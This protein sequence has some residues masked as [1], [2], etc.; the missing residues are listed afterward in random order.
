MLESYEDY[1]K[2][3]GLEDKK[4]SWINWKID[5]YQYTKEKARKRA[6]SQYYP[7]S[8]ID[9]EQTT[10]G[11]NI[12]YLRKM[13]GFTLVEMSKELNISDNC[14]ISRWERG[15]YIPDA[16][17]TQMLSDYFNVKAADLMKRNLEQEHYQ[18]NGSL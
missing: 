4:E 3:L 6:E 14:L 9:L 8:P 13:K 11:L 10:I 1:L 2:R 7:L 16:S 5:V 12:H 18:L 17:Q 15:I